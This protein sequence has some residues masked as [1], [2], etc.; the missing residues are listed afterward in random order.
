MSAKNA[1]Y[2]FKN[3]C[4]DKRFNINKNVRNDSNDNTKMIVN[5]SKKKRRNI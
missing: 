1:D 4:Y 2:F 3:T 5:D